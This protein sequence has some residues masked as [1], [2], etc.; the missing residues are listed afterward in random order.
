VLRKLLIYAVLITTGWQ[1]FFALSRTI[2]AVLA[3][4]PSPSSRDWGNIA[5]AAASLLVYGLGW[6]YYWYVRC[7]DNAAT[8]EENGAATVRRWYFY[9]ANFVALSV[10]MYAL[11]DLAR[12]VWDTTLWSEQ[13]MAW[14]GWIPWPVAND[15][16][17]I[18]AGIVVWLA[19]WLPVQRLTAVSAD[20]QRSA[21]RK[22]YLYAVIFQTMAVTLGGIALSIYNLLRLAIGTA[23]PGETSDMLVRAGGGALLTAAVYGAF[24]AY[25]WQVVKWDAELVAH[26]PPLQASIRRLYTHLVALVGLAVLATGVASM[27]RLL[28]DFWLGGSATTNLSSRAWGDEISFFATLVIT[29]GPVW[30]MSW[31]QL[32]RRALAPDG[33]EDRQSLIRRI[34]LYGVLFFSVMTLLAGGAWFIYQLLRNLGETVSSSLL[35]NMSWALGAI[36]TAGV[37]LAYHLYVLAGDLRARAAASAEPALP[38]EVSEVVPPGAGAEPA[39][40]V[41]VQGLAASAVVAAVPALRGALPEGVQIEVLQA[42]GVTPADLSSWLT[43]RRAETEATA[44]PDLR[45]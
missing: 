4:L 30:Y 20:E 34:Y 26:E 37:L 3:G 17:W 16:G 7:Q 28:F 36:I 8:P 15:A 13:L 6:L 27:L 42:P 38:G 35:S 10:C 21:L 11:A 24:W 33:T 31:S 32:Q 19:H 18:V 12:Y 41:L 23:P 44:M 43:G 14:P 2:Q 9:L 5:A 25:H 39:A 29:G 45:V 40:I 22:V 1:V